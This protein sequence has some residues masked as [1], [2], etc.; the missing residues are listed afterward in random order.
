M[1]GKRLVVWKDREVRVRW[2]QPC[3]GGQRA[4][5]REGP[6]LGGDSA[7]SLRF[8]GHWLVFEDACPHRLAP[9][10]E[11]RIN[12]ATGDLQC[13][14]HGWAFNSGGRCTLIPQAKGP[15]LASKCLSRGSAA[16]RRGP[17]PGLVLACHPSSRG[18]LNRRCSSC[19]VCILAAA[20]GSP[21]ACAR[22]YPTR[23][24]QDVLFVM[25]DASPEGW[26]AAA[27]TPVPHVSELDDDDFTEK[28]STYMRDLPYGYDT[29]L[30]NLM[31][32]Q[33]AASRQPVWLAPWCLLRRFWPWDS[34]PLPH[35]PG[36]GAYGLCCDEQDPAHVPYTHHGATGAS[37]TPVER[38][39]ANPIPMTLVRFNETG[40]KVSGHASRSTPINRVTLAPNPS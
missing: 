6:E 34:V 1:L 21:R 16:S 30:E 17:H 23:V 24:H 9:L 8:Q 13:A 14:Y 5:N 3:S 10:S 25:P 4:P 20:M 35:G 7:L 32:S 37:Q 19:L 40:L 22:V 33:P 39:N 15:E 26:A 29:L 11:G 18:G 12:P 38:E 36:H 2:P 27:N 28:G 31:V